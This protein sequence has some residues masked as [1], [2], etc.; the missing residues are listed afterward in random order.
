MMCAKLFQKCLT[1]C[2]PMAPQASLSMG[3][4]RQEYWSG[5]PRPL[6]GDLCKPEIELTH[7]MSPVLAGRYF[8]T[9]TIWEFHIPSGILG[10]EGPCVCIALDLYYSVLRIPY[11]LHESAHT[12]FVFEDFMIIPFLTPQISSLKSHV[13][14]IL[15]SLLL[16]TK[17][18]PKYDR[19]FIRQKHRAIREEETSEILQPMP[20][21]EKTEAQ[22]GFRPSS[23]NNNFIPVYQTVVCWLGILNKSK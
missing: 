20:S 13:G 3:L 8:T 18:Q 7:L 22:L 23:V 12:F 15:K 17:S 9:S 11:Y 19:N 4:S 21:F 1:L 14:D 16:H 6:P 10:S 2:D 5:L